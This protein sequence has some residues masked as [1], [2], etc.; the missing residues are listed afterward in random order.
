MQMAKPDKIRQRGVWAVVLLLLVASA[1]WAQQKLQEKPVLLDTTQPHVPNKSF[2]QFN[3][4]S[5]AWSPD[6][7]TL[8]VG[9]EAEFGVEGSVPWPAGNQ[10]QLWNVTQRVCRRVFEA[11]P[12]SSNPVV[13]ELA[14]APNGAFLTARNSS[15]R[16]GM[17]T[18]AQTWNVRTGKVVT[19]KTQFK[20][21]RARSLA[22][23]TGTPHLVAER[24]AFAILRAE[25]RANKSVCLLE[26]RRIS[27]G[28]LIST[29]LLSAR[30]GKTER[31]AECA[32]LSGDG[33]QLATLVSSAKSESFTIFDTRTAKLLRRFVLPRPPLPMRPDQV[34]RI[35]SGV[36]VSDFQPHL[37]FAREGSTLAVSI[38]YASMLLV[39]ARTGKRQSTIS[40]PHDI[41]AFALSPE[42]ARL[43]VSEIG[44]R[45]TI[46]DARTGRL[47]REVASQSMSSVPLGDSDSQPLR[48]LAFSPDSATL[49]VASG[50]GHVA[51]WRVP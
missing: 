11:S 36:Y 6:G 43:A 48:Q 3:A 22:V 29:R 39:N 27:T 26:R 8:A 19:V 2:N 50:Y 5:L 30:E 45:L 18:D 31:N 38:G 7:R 40:T 51:L 15:L 28:K 25:Q 21:S 34:H 10:I 47:L 9:G 4:T 32:A 12:V 44:G 35:Q 16:A 14:W 1:S 24:D 37:A 17:L 33:R 13:A 46:W 41:Q 49:A 23:A 42:G 20:A